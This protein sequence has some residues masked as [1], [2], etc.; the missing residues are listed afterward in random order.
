MSALPDSFSQ[1]VD[2][3]HKE[4]GIPADYRTACKL[5]VCKEPVDLVDTEPDYYNRPQKLTAE[6]HIAWTAMKQ[7]AADKG[8]SLF[9]ISAFRS[10]EYQRN[11]FKKKLAQG[12]QLN[13][14][15]GVNAAPG[16][17][18]H[19][20]G[21]AIDLS[22]INCPALEEEF[23]KTQAFEWLMRNSEEFGFTLSYPKDNPYGLNYEP[24]HWC[25]QA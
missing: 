3:L 9:L 7:A 20:T 14:I 23:E 1:R 18:E 22:T 2:Q 10:Y 11:L 17:S 4:I 25:Y 12:A 19:H 24:W 5:P 16:Y 13:E 21:R 6:A 15:L 8:V